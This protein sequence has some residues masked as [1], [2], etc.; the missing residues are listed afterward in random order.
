MPN[1]DFAKHGQEK[2][3]LV[4]NKLVFHADFWLPV[5]LFT[6]IPATTATTANAQRTS[7]QTD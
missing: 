2:L 5:S 1:L 4:S 6:A 7:I 3:L